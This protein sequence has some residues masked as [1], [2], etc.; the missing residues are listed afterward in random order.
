MVFTMGIAVG[1]IGVL[2]TG[3]A[4]EAEEIFRIAAFLFFTVVNMA[5]WLG[6]SI[7]FSVVCRHSATSALAVIALWIFFTIFMS[8]VA[9]II[10]NAVYPVNNQYLAMVNTYNNYTLNL[11]VNRISPYYLYSEAVST[12]M[13]PSIRFC[14]C[15][16]GEPAGRRH[17]QL[18]FLW[19]EYASGMAAPDCTDCRNAGCICLLLHWIYETGDPLQ[20]KE[21]VFTGCSQDEHDCLIILRYPE[22]I[23]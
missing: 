3:L 20:L 21:R 18:P 23:I 9:N 10:A 2:S 17:F 6:L 15:S 12:I 14:Q 13:N 19:T 5:F 1:A 11:N 7:L 22:T 4:P 8:L 16:D